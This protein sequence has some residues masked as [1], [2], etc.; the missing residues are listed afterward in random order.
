MNHLLGEIIAIL[1]VD[2]LAAAALRIW[3]LPLQT[4]FYRCFG[5]RS[6]AIYVR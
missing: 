4:W 1:S 5:S 6:M 3:A 2:V